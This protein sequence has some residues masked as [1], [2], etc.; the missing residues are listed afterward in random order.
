MSRVTPDPGDC[1]AAGNMN[2]ERA[3]KTQEFSHEVRRTDPTKSS[4]IFRVGNESEASPMPKN[5]RTRFIK[6]A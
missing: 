5:D 6:R 2:P 4:H 3:A 1:V